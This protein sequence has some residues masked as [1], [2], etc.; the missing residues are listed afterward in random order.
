M[1]GNRETDLV[2]MQGDVGMR[3]DRVEHRGGAG[4][5]RGDACA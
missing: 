1:T 3:I 4:R 5:I 2:E